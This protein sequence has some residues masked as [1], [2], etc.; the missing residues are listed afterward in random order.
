[1]RQPTKVLGFN[2]D[3]DVLIGYLDGTIEEDRLSH[4]D[5]E[6]LDRVLTCKSLLITHG[7]TVKA[8][9]IM[10]GEG[11]SKATAYRTLTLTQQVFGNLLSVRKELRR[12]IAEEMIRTDRE[13]AQRKEDSAAM[14]ASTRNY[15]KLFGLDKDDPE[16]PDLSDIEP[17]PNLIAFVPEQ[18]GI[19]PPSDE[20]LKKKLRA[21]WADRAQ[22]VEFEDQPK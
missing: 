3:A 18:V 7:S 8:V 4:K 15:I 16:I 5:K 19:N 17:A 2:T 21:F 13:M 22:D 1:M 11:L 9:E 20:E 6:K 14:A 10:V 12:A